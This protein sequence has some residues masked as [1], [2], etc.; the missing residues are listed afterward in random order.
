MGGPDDGK[1]TPERGG[2]YAGGG[3]TGK[4]ANFN[5]LDTVE[6]QIATLQATIDQQNAQ[7]QQQNATITQQ[8]Q[9]NQELELLSIRSQ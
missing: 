3:G 1:G 8:Q 4:G 5:R 7:M 6:A 9:A 2:P